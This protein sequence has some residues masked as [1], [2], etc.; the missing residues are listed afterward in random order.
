MVTFCETDL[1]S[2]TILSDNIPYL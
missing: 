2:M 1:L